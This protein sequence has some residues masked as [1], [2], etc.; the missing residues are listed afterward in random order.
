MSN[1]KAQSSNEIQSSNNKIY[2]KKS[3]LTLSHFD[4]HLAL[5]FCH[6]DLISL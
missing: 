1:V 3:D 5:G 6:L 2:N 4:I